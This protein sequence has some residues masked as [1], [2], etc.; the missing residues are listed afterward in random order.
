M[1]I[2]SAALCE[3]AGVTEVRPHTVGVRAAEDNKSGC[4]D[5]QECPTR[6]YRFQFDL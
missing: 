6:F 3:S 1:Y 2:C 5:T 4:D